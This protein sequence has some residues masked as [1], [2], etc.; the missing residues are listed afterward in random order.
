MNGNSIVEKVFCA[1]KQGGFQE[2]IEKIKNHMREK[3]DS[4]RDFLFIYSGELEYKQKERTLFLEHIWKLELFNY[5][6]ELVEED[7]LTIDYLRYFKVFICSIFTAHPKI[8]FFT[9]IY[10]TVFLTAGNS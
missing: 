7:N 10:F 4:Y 6:A 2:I 3:K 1:F 5:S 9:F 8:I